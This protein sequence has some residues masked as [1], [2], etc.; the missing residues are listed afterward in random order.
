MAV[1]HSTDSQ[2]IK[3]DN[4]KVDVLIQDHHTK[5]LIDTGATLS[6]IGESM[7]TQLSE[8]KPERVEIGD[9]DCCTVANGDEINITH[10]VMVKL[11]L[12]KTV[13]NVKLYILPRTYVDIII[14]VDILR[15]LG[16]IIDFI[17]DELQL[18]G[19]CPKT[20]KTK[21]CSIHS[22]GYLDNT[23]MPPKQVNQLQFAPLESHMI[24][25]KSRC[26]IILKSNDKIT[27][28]ELIHYDIE[29]TEPL[30]LQF[31]TESIKHNNVSEIVTVVQN[32]N[33]Q[34]QYLLSDKSIMT[35]YNKPRLQQ[36]KI[37]SDKIDLSK[38]DL[39]DTQKQEVKTLLDSFSDVFA[40]NIK[41]IGCTNLLTYDIRLKSNVKPIRMRPYKTG[42]KQREIIE[43]QVDEWLES[44]IIRPSMS[45][46]SFPCLLVAKKGTDKMRLVV[47]FRL[48]NSQ[49]ELP[50]YPLIDLE[51]FLADLGNKKSTYFTTFD[52]KS[53]YLQ[54][55]LSERSQELCS[56]VC[57]KG[58]FSFLRA[59]FG[60]CALPLVFARLIDEVLRG[61]KHQFTQT[62]I[63]DI[64]LYSSSFSQHMH[65]IDIVLSRLREAGL[66][67]EPNKTHIARK[68]L[69][70]IGYT[71]SKHGIKTDPSN[72]DKVK[73]FPLPKSTKDVRSFLGLSNYYRRFIKSYAK[74]ARPLNE[75]LKKHI[76]FEWSTQANDAFE[77]LR[78]KLITSPILAFPDLNSDE[79]LRLTC[80][81]SLFGSGYVLSQN[82]PDPV[83]GELT[84]RAI[85][86]GSR[87]FTETQQRYTVTERE[88]LAVVFAVEKLDQY[89]RCKKFIIITDHSSL[90]WLLSKSLSNINARLARWVLA[91]GQY[92]FSIV[93]KPGTTI[94]NADSLSRLQCNNAHEDISFKV[95]PYINALSSSKQDAKIDT[96]IDKTVTEMSIPGLEKLSVENLRES[97]ENDYWFGAIKIYI[98]SN[99]LPTSKKLMQRILTNHQEYILINDILYHI[100]TAKG[101]TQE[102]VQQ[103]CITNDLKGLIWKAMHEIPNSGHLGITKTYA[104]LRN[105]YFWPKMSSETTDYVQKCHICATANKG[106]QAKIPLQPLPVPIGPLESIHMDILSISVPSQGAKYILVIIC[107]FSK[108]V[109]ARPLK[110]KTS[111]SVA[112]TFFQ[113]YIQLFGLP[114]QLTVTQ[115][116]GGEFRGNFNQTLHKMLGIKSIFIT[117]YSPSSNGMV[118]KTN[119]TL[120][121]ILRRYAM[122]EASK[123]ALYLPY[124][125]MAINSAMT[126]T[127]KLS[128]FE[129]IHGV[130]MR[131]AIDLQLPTPPKFIT[132]DHQAAYNYWQAHLKKIR[133]LARDK[134]F[135]AKLNQKRQYDRYAE[136]SKYKLGDIVYLRKTVLGSSECPKLRAMYTGPYILQRFLSPT[137][138]ILI[139]QKTETKLPRSYHINKLKRIRSKRTAK[140]ISKSDQATETGYNEDISEE[141]KCTWNETSNDMSNRNKND[142]NQKLIGAKATEKEGLTI[143][144]NITA[145][146][147][148]CDRTEIESEPQDEVSVNKGITSG[149]NLG[150]HINPSDDVIQESHMSPENAP[151]EEYLEQEVEQENNVTADEIY[152][153]IKKIHRK[154]MT[155]EG[156]REYYVSWQDRPKRDNCWIPEDNLSEDLKIK[157][158]TL[159]IPETKSNTN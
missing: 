143:P 140:Q 46:W 43:D 147:P 9:I 54:V 94:T 27:P 116:N 47:D 15:Q 26:R 60:L 152:Y 145:P 38:S 149:N 142:V 117:P 71:F 84:E 25:P 53:A 70:F 1:K 64:L 134:L 157:A 128:P 131:E 148:H 100:W 156:D 63:D 44:G 151:M 21:E 118:E 136:P 66:T 40:E 112:K 17:H 80:D 2:T 99:E 110:R 42:W 74:I 13:V 125:V 28:C 4:N 120:L 55:P 155:S 57:S 29:V 144:Y 58:Q 33:N 102:P 39:T 85:A 98:T 11:T 37:I 8:V 49:S 73:H 133:S 109:I 65:H 121:S 88:L 5:A 61:T 90:Q 36:N 22:L 86:Y 52:L 82:Q 89:L 78:E 104:K 79:P 83:A 72:I 135:Q 103:I 93:H 59:P 126:E 115:D 48:L 31:Q 68:E 122:K 6:V 130:E 23:V 19:L 12:G 69:V 113:Y 123:W 35:I 32:E 108:Y 92:N 105:R 138:V 153:P 45:E 107:A 62:F 56:F 18:P 106:Q 97:Q 34:P 75:L 141:K 50:N 76:K 129:M 124:A 111:R 154:R 158:N 77:K 30:T 146:T 14:G 91:L 101:N 132:N 10:T 41:D 119:R 96:R 3:L 127:T 159:K 114:R 139:D 67:V 81:A 137:N 7:I 150:E 51:E 16:A 24:P 95:E 20:T 87:N